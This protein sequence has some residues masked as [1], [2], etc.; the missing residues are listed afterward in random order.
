MIGGGDWAADRI[1][2]DAMRSLAQGEPIPVRNLAATRPWQHVIEPLAGYL[3]LAEAL[4]QAGVP[5]ESRE[6]WDAH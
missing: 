5:V 6:V 1:V 2:P 3:R 4:D